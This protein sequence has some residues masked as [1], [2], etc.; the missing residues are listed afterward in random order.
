MPELVP[1]LVLVPAGL[2]VLA[3]AGP[4]LAVLEPVLALAPMLAR[5]QALKPVAAQDE[6]LAQPSMSV[7]I[8]NLASLASI[9][10][11]GNSRAA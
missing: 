9:E 8:R 3:L 1:E 10:I 5:V 7:A 11:V 6:L 2:A 4:A